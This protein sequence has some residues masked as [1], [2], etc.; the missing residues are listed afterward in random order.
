VEK[1]SKS[2]CRDCRRRR[3]RRIKRRRQEEERQG[4]GTRALRMT[5]RNVNLNYWESVCKFMCVVI[6]F[7]LN[8]AHY[9]KVWKAG[10]E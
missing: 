10:M 2:Y 9:I 1:D 7:L 5:E 6:L 8:A 4:G 3:R